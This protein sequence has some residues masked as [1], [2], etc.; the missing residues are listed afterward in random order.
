MSRAPILSMHRT[1]AA[2]VMLRGPSRGLLI[3][4]ATTQTW[5]HTR[6]IAE[7]G[8]EARTVEDSCVLQAKR[9]FRPQSSRFDSTAASG[10]E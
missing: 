4:H 2:C 3:G 1:M 8:E 7:H 9:Q 6:G 5:Q 10:V